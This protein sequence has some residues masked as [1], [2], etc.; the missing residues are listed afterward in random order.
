[1]PLVCALSPST[2]RNS[3][4]KI[5]RGGATGGTRFATSPPTLQT[6]KRLPLRVKGEDEMDKL[7]SLE[8]LFL[9][10][11]KDLYS[12]EQQILQALPKMA[13]ATEHEE[14][15]RAFREHE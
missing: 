14:L 3:T 5:L 7:N 8:D 4:F 6:P 9:H 11:L 15:Q 10:E 12:A 13:G 2:T 1:S